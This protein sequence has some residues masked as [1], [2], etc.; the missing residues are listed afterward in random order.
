MKVVEKIITEDDGERLQ[1]RV[2]KL[3]SENCKLKVAAVEPFEDYEVLGL[4]NA[5]LLS[6]HN[7]AC[8]RCEDL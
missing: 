1:K 5:S 6:E 4:A 7:E 3:E 8:Y 2:T